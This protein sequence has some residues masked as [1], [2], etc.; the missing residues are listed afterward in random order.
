M[1]EKGISL[2]EVTILRILLIRFYDVLLL[3]IQLAGVLKYIFLSVGCL[4]MY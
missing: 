1:D 4:Y 2:C 3:E